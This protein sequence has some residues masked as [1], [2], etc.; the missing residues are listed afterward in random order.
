M[1]DRLL[2]PFGGVRVKRVQACTAGSAS[3]WAGVVGGVGLGARVIV[4]GLA[5]A[6]P[7]VQLP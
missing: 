6:G 5:A 7:G 2:W 4:A 1:H 3:G